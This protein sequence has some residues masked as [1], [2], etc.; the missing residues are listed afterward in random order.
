M[1][2]QTLVYFYNMPEINNKWGRRGEG[3]D[4]NKWHMPLHQIKQAHND[5]IFKIFGAISFN[6]IIILI[7]KDYHFYISSSIFILVYY[8]FIYSLLLRMTINV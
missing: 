3:N 4:S 8:L 1:T 2:I 5:S 7:F 6:N